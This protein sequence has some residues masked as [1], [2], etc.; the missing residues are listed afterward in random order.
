M[1]MVS[2]RQA[3]IRSAPRGEAEP[4][5][6]SLAWAALEELRR[7]SGPP[8]FPREILIGVAQAVEAIWVVLAGFASFMFFAPG[9]VIAGA[10]PI[11]RKPRQRVGSARQPVPHSRP[12]GPWRARGRGPRRAPAFA[13]LV[14]PPTT[15]ARSAAWGHSLRLCS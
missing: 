5:S 1:T 4:V 2:S 12:T 14:T 8:P 3:Y 7:Q 13:T 15:R 9:A 6:N 11:A 10:A